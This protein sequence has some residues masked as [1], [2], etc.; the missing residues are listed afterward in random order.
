ML[1]CNNN[2]YELSNATQVL[3]GIVRIKSD[4][5]MNL[6]VVQTSGKPLMTAYNSI[7]AYKIT[8][9]VV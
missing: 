7:A 4:T 8:D 2:G 3:S 9:I 5:K 6:H 1:L